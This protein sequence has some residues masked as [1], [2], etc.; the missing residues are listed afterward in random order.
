MVGLLHIRKC[1]C[2]A[3]LVLVLKPFIHTLVLH[4]VENK[5]NNSRYTVH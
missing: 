2:I 3:V 1:Q 5:Q 4:S